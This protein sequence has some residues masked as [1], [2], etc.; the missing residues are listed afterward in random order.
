MPLKFDKVIGYRPTMEDILEDLGIS[1][2][3]EFKETVL[4]RCRELYDK[5]KASS[6]IATFEDSPYEFILCDSSEFYQTL[7]NTGRG[8]PC[9][10]IMHDWSQEAYFLMFTDK[11][12][13]EFYPIAVAHDSAEYEEIQR[14][15]DQAIAH[16]RATVV[17]IE[18]AEH[19]GLK[20]EY[21]KFLEEAYPGK[22]AELDDRGLIGA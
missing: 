19:L 12:P 22:Y 14:G 8:S 17:E 20:K 3:L 5:A 18:T 11:M 1:S 13:E 9:L 16:N 4:G 6:N 21:L 10:T 2:M 15:I 7:V